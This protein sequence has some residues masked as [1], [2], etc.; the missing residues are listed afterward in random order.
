MDNAVALV[1]AYLHVN[2]YFTVTEYPVLEALRTGGYRIATDIDILALRLPHAGGLVPAR[3]GRRTVDRDFSVDPALQSSLD[4]SDLIVGEVK[5]GSAEL[6]QG[7]RHPHVLSAVLSRFACCTPADT[8]AVVD[9][10]LQNGEATT[11]AGLRVRLMAFGATVGPQPATG[12]TRL[13]LG[14]IVWFLEQHLN[15]HW[16]VLRVAQIKD[17]VFGFLMTL[18]KA[19]RGAGARAPLPDPQPERER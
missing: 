4:Q 19:R 18:E 9:G 16:D 1:R 7:A 12:Y 8:K 17:P 6:N 15:R 3:L 10:L 5:E 2:G 14:H 13:S 11:D